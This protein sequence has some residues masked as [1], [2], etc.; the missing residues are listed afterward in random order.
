VPGYQHEAPA[1]MEDRAFGRAHRSECR[2][3][4]KSDPNG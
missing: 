2:L 3:E 4:Q 1:V